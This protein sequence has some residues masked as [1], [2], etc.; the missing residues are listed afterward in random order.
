MFF[1]W[2]LEAATA[3]QK[4]AVQSAELSLNAS[5]VIW[6]RSLMMGTGQMR[7]AEATRMV[8]EKPIAFSSAFL[9]GG[10]AALHHPMGAQAALCTLA[11]IGKRARNNAKRLRRT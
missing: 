2:Y 9:R 6:R 11:P 5:E 1:K 8:F 10:W 4:V 7:P 3:W